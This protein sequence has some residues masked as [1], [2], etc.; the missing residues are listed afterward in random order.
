MLVLGSFSVNDMS[1]V[2]DERKEERCRWSVHFIRWV[3]AVHTEL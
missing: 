3:A 1:R 2:A